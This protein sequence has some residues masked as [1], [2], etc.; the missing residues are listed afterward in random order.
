MAIPEMGHRYRRPL[1]R[2]PGKGEILGRGDR[3]LYKVGRG[4]TIGIITG[5]QIKRFVW[6]NIVCRFGLPQSIASDNGKQFAHDPFGSWCKQLQIEQVFTSVAHPQA[7]GQVERANRSIVEGIKARLGRE[8]AGCVEEL[9][10]V[11]WAHRTATKTSN[12]ETPFSLTYGTEAMIPVE[13][14][15][16]TRR[17]RLTQEVNDLDLRFNLNLLEE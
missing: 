7:N 16:P 17:T 14:G 11:L 8:R 1:P 13:I 15:S 9:P 3:L 2:S 10:H 12:G 4:Q 6:E 5:Q